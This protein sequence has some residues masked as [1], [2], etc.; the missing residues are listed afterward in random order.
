MHCGTDFL[1][2]FYWGN[3]IYNYEAELSKQDDM[4]I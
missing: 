1:T 3:S 2:Q 4:F